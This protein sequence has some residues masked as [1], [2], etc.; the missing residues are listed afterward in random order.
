MIPFALHTWHFALLLFTVWEYWLGETKVLYANSTLSL[1]FTV[2]R[3]V[4]CV[5]KNKLLGRFK[6]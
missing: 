1:F 3:I 4:L 2:C 6:K 5:T